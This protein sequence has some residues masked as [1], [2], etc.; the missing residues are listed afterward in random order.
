MCCSVYMFFIDLTFFFLMIRPPP[1]S[2]LFPYTTLFRSLDPF[3]NPPRPWAFWRS[4]HNVTPLFS[5]FAFSHGTVADSLVAGS[6][7]ITQFAPVTGGAIISGRYLFNAQR[8]DLY[9]DTL[10][11]EVIRGTFV[12]P[13]RTRLDHC[14]GCRSTTSSR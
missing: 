4:S 6:I 13:L 7:T 10:G 5:I 9:N 3:C 2:T 1:S 14:P 8:T 11:V 12:A